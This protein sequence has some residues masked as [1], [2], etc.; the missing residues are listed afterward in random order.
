[1]KFGAWTTNQVLGEG[2]QA[3]TYRVCR[4]DGEIAALKVFRDD[5]HLA[6]AEASLLAKLDHP[7]IPRFIES[8]EADGAFCIAQE[9]IDGES[10][11]SVLD[12]R[13][14]IPEADVLRVARGLLGIVAYLHGLDPPV[15]HRDIKPANVV[16]KA[17]GTVTLVDFGGGLCANAVGEIIGTTGFAAPEQYFGDVTAAVDLYAIG[18]TLLHLAS[19]TH[20]AE[21]PMHRMRFALDRNLVAGEKLVALIGALTEPEI[22]NRLPDAAA[23]LRLLT[24]DAPLEDEEL[25][26]HRDEDRLVV[27][28]KRRTPPWEVAAFVA[29]TAFVVFLVGMQ[30]SFHSLLPL[31]AWA[32]LALAWLPSLSREHLE[33]DANGYR[34]RATLF[35]VTWRARAGTF[36]PGLSL[37]QQGESM[38]LY[39]YDAR[40]IPQMYQLITPRKT[41]KIANA[42]RGWIADHT[43]E[44]VLF[45]GLSDAVNAEAEHEGSS[46]AH[47][48]IP[49]TQEK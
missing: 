48:S 5:L 29:M 42:V 1:M 27:V 7:R 43:N 11:Q 23:A 18:A 9:F 39:D 30:S 35:G 46:T 3:A 21:F 40:Q 15:V 26:L 17:D 24:H 36:T 31:A 22:Q 41:E 10:L 2:G 33:L 8:F 25:D 37:L 28:T 34:Y 12:S 45:G 38:S 6:R 4:A 13:R 19:G 14:H 32:C 49:A 20:P 47:S 16:M 44:T